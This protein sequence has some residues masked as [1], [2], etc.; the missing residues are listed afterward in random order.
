MGKMLGIAAAD[1]HLPLSFLDRSASFPASA[2]TRDFQE[3]N[4]NAY[5]DVL[6]FG[7]HKD[8]LTIEIEH[9][10]IGALRELQEAGVVVHPHPDALHV[11]KDKGL[12][13]EFY[14]EH[15]FPTSSFAL[16]AG[17]AEIRDAVA[18]E[19]L[20]LPF[21]QK[22]RTEGYDGRGVLVVLEESQLD[23]LL[24]GPSIVEELVPI[25]KELAVIAA[26]NA[27][28]EVRT[29]PPVEMTFHPEVNLVEF[30]I[31]PARIP[32]DIARQA[33]MLAKRLIETFGICGLLAVEFFL[34]TEGALLVNEVAPRP[35]NSGHHTINSCVTSQFQQHLRGILNLP[36]GDTTLH[37]PA[38][39]VNLL[40]EPGQEGPV[41]YEGMDT[42]LGLDGVYLHLYGKMETRPFRKMGHA[43][44]VDPN[45]GAA[46]LKARKV[47]DWFRVTSASTCQ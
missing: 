41:S 33:D 18:R 15:G 12:Q 23:E 34:S 20:G 36:L 27:Q 37:T 32:E 43:T 14:A 1:W 45:L 38:V 26:R 39:M 21:V 28:G 19:E 3:G 31:C 5:S 11:I 30:L 6:A 16:Y 35:H 46:I 10:H 25:A 9:V 22:A 13:K 40:G 2:V 29:F 44:I 17:A 24:E 47:S 7:R 4:F 8:V 42:C